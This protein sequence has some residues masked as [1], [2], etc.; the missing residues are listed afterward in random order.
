MRTPQPLV[1]PDSVTLHLHLEF[2]VYYGMIIAEQ[3]GDV[4]LL[5]TNSWLC[6]CKNTDY[7]CSETCRIWSW[8]LNIAICPLNNFIVLW[9]RELFCAPFLKAVSG[10]VFCCD[11]DSEYW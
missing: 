10:N 2:C 3:L 4:L 8:L 11:F 7:C 5:S 6:R 1:M 9:A